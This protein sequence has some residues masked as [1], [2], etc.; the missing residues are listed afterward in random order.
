M[1]RQRGIMALL[2][3]E[4]YLSH[5]REAFRYVKKKMFLG[6]GNRIFGQA[7]GIQGYNARMVCVERIVR[8]QT[9]ELILKIQQEEAKITREKVRARWGENWKSVI[10]EQARKQAE[11]ENERRWRARAIAVNAQYA[12]I[13]GC[14]NCEEQSSLT[15]HF[16]R[17]KG[18]RPI[19]LFMHG[20]WLG[21]GFGS[22][23]FVILG[24]DGKTDIGNPGG[25]NREAVWCDPYEDQVGGLDKI[26]DRFGKEKL[27]L[28]FRWE[29]DSPSKSKP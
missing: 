1:E 20:G 21:S 3:Y 24:R 7:S 14:G 2:I 6:A 4:Q 13:F 18:I 16:L 29:G 27:N 11:A 5:A 9:K 8:P 26:K 17:K 12:E 10:T 25:W 23:A 28:L 15:F 19:D 22:H